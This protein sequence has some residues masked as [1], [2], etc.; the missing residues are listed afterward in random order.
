MITIRPYFDQDWEA[1][2]RVH[3]RAQPSEFVGTFDFPVKSSLAENYKIQMLLP[4]CLKFVA[5]D[6][7]TVVGFLIIQ[8]HAIN[9]LYVDPDCQNQ[10][11]G[12]RLLQLALD[13]MGSPVWTVTIAGNMRARRFYQ[14]AGFQLV[15]QFEGKVKDHPCQFVRLKWGEDT[16][17]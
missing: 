13:I 15:D 12:G 9:L 2:C 11:I 3:D 8:G 16:S 5:C 10:G 4:Q 1:I 14:R 7:E 17:S 6:G